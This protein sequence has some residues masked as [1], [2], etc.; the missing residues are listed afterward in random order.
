MASRMCVYNNGF[1]NEFSVPTLAMWDDVTRKE[2]ISGV[3]CE[4]VGDSKNIQSQ[5]VVSYIKS[6]YP[7]YL[8]YLFRDDVKKK[9]KNASFTELSKQ[10]NDTNWSSKD[11]RP[12][13]NLSRR[14]RIT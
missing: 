12:K 8:H 2:I 5:S 7:G 10:M 9:G 4:D 13:I 11:S 1:T 3:A 14:Q 6:L